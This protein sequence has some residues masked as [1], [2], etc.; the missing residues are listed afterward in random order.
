MT[1]LLPIEPFRWWCDDCR[2]PAL[3]YVERT[4]WSKARANE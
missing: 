3:E 4:Y 2:A 1:K